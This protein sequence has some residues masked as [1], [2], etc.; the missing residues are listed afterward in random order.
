MGAN[1][2][3]PL[4]ITSYVSG[5]ILQAKDV[6]DELVIA[7]VRQLGPSVTRWTLGD[8]LPAVPPKVLLAKLRALVRRGFLDGCACGCSGFFDVLTVPIE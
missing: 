6:S 2:A 8:A 3:I 4:C 5:G 7:L 1:L